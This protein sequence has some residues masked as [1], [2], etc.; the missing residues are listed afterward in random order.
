MV[1]PDRWVWSTIE[2]VAIAQSGVGFPKSLQGKTSGDFPLVKVS[3]ISNAVKEFGGVLHRANNYLSDAEAKKIGAKIFPSGTAMFAKIGE[4]VRLNR[5][6]LVAL[7]LLAD[8]NV[9]GLLPRD[10]IVPKYLFYFLHTIDLYEYSQ[11]TTVP[12]V[13]KTDVLQ[14]PLPLP[15]LDEQER[16]VARIESLLTQLDAGVAALKRVQVVLKRYRA[17]VLKS[18]CEGRLVL[19]DPNDEPAE[20][21]LQLFSKSPLAGDDFSSLPSGWCWVR[22]GDISKQSQC[23][24]SEKA[25]LD[26]SGIPVL[27][28]GNIQNGQLDFDNL[29]YLPAELPEL[30][31]LI[32]EDGDLIFNRTNSAELVG[33]T[34]V[35]KKH[36][37]RATFASYLIRIKFQEIF[38]SDYVC[39]YI[40]SLY[41]RKYISS[42]VSQQVGQANV[43]G[44]KL[45]NMP[46]PL[47]PLSEQRR[48]VAEVE[49]QL[50]M[51]QELEQT[52]SIN[53]KRAARM[54]QAILQRALEG[55][56]V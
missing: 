21:L 49:R 11:A 43:N 25:N 53:L 33:K 20:V 19:Q 39:I 55:K 31:N 24:T 28:M 45:A 44:K 40:N 48:I 18:A 35:Y 54:R 1:L 30:E 3:D 51:V 47:P 56:L 12:S 46:L 38:L 8:N 32:L 42:V 50:S 34:A 2:D 29:K 27:R 10:N 16:I 36:H 5:R 15:P 13:R 26:S 17:S 14:I 22:V 9:M 52:V 7:P 37:P 6:A 4:A 23:G 41:G